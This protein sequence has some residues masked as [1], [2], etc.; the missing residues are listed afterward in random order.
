MNKKKLNIL[1]LPS[2][3][4]N[5]GPKLNRKFLCIPKHCGYFYA[6]HVNKLNPIKIEERKCI[7]YKK[8]SLRP[9]AMLSIFSKKLLSHY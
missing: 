8:P 1:L 7:R 2:N 3:P 6:C 4:N 5:S 9:K